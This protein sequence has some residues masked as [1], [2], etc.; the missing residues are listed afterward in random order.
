V[1]AMGSRA[2]GVPGFGMTLVEH[3]TESVGGPVIDLQDVEGALEGLPVLADWKGKE[4]TGLNTDEQIFAART[5]KLLFSVFLVLAERP[6]YLERGERRL[7]KKRR[8]EG[9]ELWTPNVIGRAYRLRRE[10]AGE[11]AASDVSPRMHWRRGHWRNQACGV[12]LGDRRHM[13]IEPMLVN[14]P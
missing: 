4:N 12:G 9:P 1:V 10:T 2:R 11:G 3:F 8:A 14:A 7:S 5:L 6:N 13:W